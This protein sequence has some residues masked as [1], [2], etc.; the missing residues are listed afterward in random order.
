[1]EF[2]RSKA[3]GEIEYKSCAAQASTFH[4]GQLCPRP[5]VYYRKHCKEHKSLLFQ[6]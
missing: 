5:T 3:V 2:R 4:D 1:M 6:F